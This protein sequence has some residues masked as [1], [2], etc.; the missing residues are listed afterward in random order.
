LPRA[1]GARLSAAQELAFVHALKGD[2][3]TAESWA[4][5]ARKRLSATYDS[6]VFFAARLCLAEAVI[7]MRRGDAAESARNLEQ[8][9]MV[10]RG[11]L[12]ANSMRV[13]EI[14]RAFAEAGGGLR[15]YNVVQ[16]RRIRVEPVAGNEFAF[17]GVAWPEMQSFLDSHGLIALSRA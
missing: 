5:D 11:S 7:A 17:L 4:N 3:S 13:A 2:L 15:Q 16:E 6:R 8:S 1:S 14:L 12:D 10:M 9:W